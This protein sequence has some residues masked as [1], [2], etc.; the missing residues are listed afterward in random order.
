MTGEKL[1]CPSGGEGQCYGHGGGNMP[2]RR[3]AK[4]I[5]HAYPIHV[6]RPGPAPCP[7]IRARGAASAKGDADRGAAPA[8]AQG[9]AALLPQHRSTADEGGRKAERPGAPRLRLI[10][11]S[12]RM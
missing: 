12:A 9:D 8:P 3:K 10:T 2:P 7:A 5:S 1:V 4:E 6:P 11:H